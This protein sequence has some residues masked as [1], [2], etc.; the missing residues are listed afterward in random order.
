MKKKIVT[1]IQNSTLF[2]SQPT[3]ITLIGTRRVSK[4]FFHFKWKVKELTPHFL[5]TLHQLMVNPMV[6]NLEK[7]PLFT[8]LRDVLEH[9]LPENLILTRDV[10]KVNQMH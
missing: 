10:L 4:L 9:C 2:H 8:R 1:P 3:T 7:T 6:H 5:S